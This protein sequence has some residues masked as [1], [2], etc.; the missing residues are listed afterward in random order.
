MALF[1]T[2]IHK[3]IPSK[4]L[5]VDITVK[6]ATTFRCF[7]PTWEM[8]MGYKNGG[9]TKEQYT[10]MYATIAQAAGWN[11]WWELVNMAREGDIALAC[12][13]LPGNFCHRHLLC[14]W[15]SNFAQVQGI[16]LQMGGEI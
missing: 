16:A 15:V 3:P 11:K 9:I 7:A 4:V 8:V 1:T 14:D 12:F 2:T 5:R 13:C 10:A 6:S